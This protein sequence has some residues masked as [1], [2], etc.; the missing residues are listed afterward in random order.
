MNITYPENVDPMDRVLLEKA[1]K[2]LEKTITTTSSGVPAMNTTSGGLPSIGTA[3]NININWTSKKDNGRLFY[4]LTVSSPDAEANAVFY[5]SDLHD[6][7][8]PPVLS[9][10][11]ARLW[12]DL[13][14]KHS[15]KQFRELMRSVE[16][17]SNA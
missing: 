4:V 14:E 13:L 16:Q 15:H 17:G 8:F 10:R 6:R 1:T 5:P 9:F 11:M 3:R 2:L 7:A 12:G